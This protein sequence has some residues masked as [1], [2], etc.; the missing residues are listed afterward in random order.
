MKKMKLREPSG[1]AIV[2]L[3]TGTVRIHQMKRPVYVK[4]ATTNVFTTLMAGK[5]K[6]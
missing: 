6:A 3:K 5:A 1:M 4:Y 2:R